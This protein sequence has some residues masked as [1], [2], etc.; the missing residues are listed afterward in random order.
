MEEGT[1][2]N[3]DAQHKPTRVHQNTHTHLS[4][5]DNAH[6]LQAPHTDDIS[7]PT[8]QGNKQIIAASSEC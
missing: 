7:S 4:V 1:V 6:T 5:H 3:P 2:V 8:T